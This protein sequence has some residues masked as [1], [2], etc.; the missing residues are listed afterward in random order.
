MLGHSQVA[1]FAD[2]YASLLLEASAEAARKVE[3]FMADQAQEP[4][5]ATGGT[6]K[7]KV[8]RLGRPRSR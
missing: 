7:E 3:A 2:T 8:R 6:G 4:K 5:V 1:V